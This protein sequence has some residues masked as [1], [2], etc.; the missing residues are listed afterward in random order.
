[1]N[2]LGINRQSLYDTFGDKETFYLAALKRYREKA[3]EQL[4][5]GLSTSA[6]LREQLKTIFEQTIG[7]S[8]AKG[9]YGCFMINSMVELGSAEGPAR[10]LATTHAREIEGVLAQRISAAQRSGEISRDK[11]PIALAR[12]IYH[13]MLGMGVAARSLGDRE[14][15]LESSRLVLRILD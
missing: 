4:R 7:M 10:A 2:E 8:C 12:F 9:G 15:L 3:V 11:D 5:C 13:S 1:M 14:S 6:P